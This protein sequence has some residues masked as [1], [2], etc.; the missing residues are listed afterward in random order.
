M[1]SWLQK[2][3]QIENGKVT[4]VNGRPQ[5]EP[6]DSDEY[7]HAA[8]H[9]GWAVDSRSADGRHVQL[10]KFFEHRADAAKAAGA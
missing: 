3:V 2:S 10:K 5:A 4:H 8:D 6:Q 1:C 9:E 7:L